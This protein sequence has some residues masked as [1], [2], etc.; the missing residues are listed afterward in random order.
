MRSR[1]NGRADP[2]LPTARDRQV[3]EAV[4]RHGYMTRPQIHRLCF[5]RDG[6]P[7]SEQA[8]CRRL[9]I[10]TDRG[11]LVRGRLSA[12][13]GS[14]PYLYRPGPLAGTA[15]EGEPLAVTGTR[16]R[17][18]STTGVNH[19]LEIVE[20][21]I[22]LKETLSRRGGEIVAWLGEAEARHTFSHRGREVAFTPDAYCLWA[23]AGEEGAFFLEWDRGTEGVRRIAEKLARYDAYYA[24]QIHHDHLGEIGLRPRLLIVVPDGRREK[25]LIRWLGKRQS[26]DDYPSLPT[27]LIGAWPTVSGDVLGP[28]WRTPGMGEPMRFSD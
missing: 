9:R 3:I 12:S 8:V 18:E 25:K 26:T 10:L 22:E 24:L 7:I 17:T 6:Q 27:V 21:Y 1:R 20:F 28:F 14:G 15:L 13:A 4:A 2:V 16:R 19:T 23:L 5:R 11:Y